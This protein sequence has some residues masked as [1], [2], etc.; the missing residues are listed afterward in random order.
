MAHTRTSR[1]GV[2]AGLHPALRMPVSARGGEHREEAG[3]WARGTPW[4]ARG[5]GGAARCVA[6]AQSLA[7]TGVCCLPPMRSSHRGT[8]QAPSH[9]ARPSTHPEPCMKPRGAGIHRLPPHLR[10]HTRPTPSARV[11]A[12]VEEVGGYTPTALWARIPALTLIHASRGAAQRQH[13]PRRDH[14]LTLHS[15]AEGVALGRLR[16]RLPG[17]PQKCWSSLHQAKIQH[18]ASTAFWRHTE[19]G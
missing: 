14:L 8:R 17:Q 5:Q 13:R 4:S 9:Y 1:E 12:A 15:I 16:A 3:T 10:T 6:P 11:P 18:G 2:S 19:Q 7:R